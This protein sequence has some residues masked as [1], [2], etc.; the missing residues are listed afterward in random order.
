MAI[1][2]IQ[3][4]LSSHL[5]TEAHDTFEKLK[6][7]EN[8]WKNVLVIPCKGEGSNIVYLLQ[9]LIDKNADL[10]IILVINANSQDE[11]EYHKI[12]ERLA[13]TVKSSWDFRALTQCKYLSKNILLIERGFG[14]FLFPDKQGVGLARRIGADIALSLIAGGQVRIPWIWTTDADAKLPDD[15][16]ASLEGLSHE[17]SAATYAFSHAKGELK[18]SE[19]RAL[20]DYELF[21][22]YYVKGLKFARS[23]YAYH[24]VGSCL[25]IQADAYAKV[26]GFP[27]KEA[28]EDFYI[29][30]KLAKV[31]KVLKIES[32][33]IILSGR[34]STRTPFG[35]GP[36]TIDIS[37]LHHHGQK[38]LVYDHRCFKE[39]RQ[40]LQFFEDW[41][42]EPDWHASSALSPM[43]SNYFRKIGGLEQLASLR[44][45]ASHSM[46]RLRR[47][48]E[49]FDAFQSLK[50]IHHFTVQDYP[51]IPLKDA[52]ED[53]EKAARFEGH[54]TRRSESKFGVHTQSRQPQVCA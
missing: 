33:P 32:K 42:E 23:P 3:K 51:K 13:Q 48:H 18:E 14:D 41:S 53:L 34:L 37:K 5:R 17:Y 44:M 7:S 10:L 6:A 43:L 27:L 1:K 31:G 16:F 30:N 24:S 35:T 40:L 2:S 47:L 11:M 36:S 54:E 26:R 9:E 15:Y 19:F 28:G 46:D 4:Y 39:L 25:A 38:Y 12:N 45:R 21:L 20:R 50:L 22:H 8:H 52:L 29:L 49:W